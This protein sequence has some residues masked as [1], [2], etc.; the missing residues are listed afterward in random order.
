LPTTNGVWLALLVI[1]NFVLVTGVDTVPVQAV[2][3]QVG[4]SK[5]VAVTVFT[6]GLTA[7]ASTVTGTL[8]VIVPTLAPAGIVHPVKVV[9]PATAV[10]GH[11]RDPE[12]VLFAATIEGAPDR[13]MP[14]GK[15]SV[16]FMAAV[17]G[18]PVSTI[19]MV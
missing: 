6:L 3:V 2:P 16:R 13:T 8:I 14:D 9:P 1:V 10:P 4:K 17:V 18:T 12:L 7:V 19:V 5:P 11:D 15:A